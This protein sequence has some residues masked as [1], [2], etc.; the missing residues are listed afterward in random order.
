MNGG[1][2]I[3]DPINT[4]EMGNESSTARVE[5]LGHIDP[6]TLTEEEFNKHAWLYHA[7][8]VS[9]FSVCKHFDYTQA[10]VN[11]A[12]LG[13]GLYTTSSR[14]QA[15]NYMRARP[16]GATLNVLLPYHAKLLNLTDPNMLTNISVPN[17]IVEEW[18]IFARDKILASIK[19]KSTNWVVQQRLIDVMNKMNAINSEDHVDLRNDILDTGNSPFSIVDVLWR[20]F[21]ASKGW[22]GVIYVEGGIDD[23]SN[24]PDRTY[25]FYNIR[26]IGTYQDWQERSPRY[27][28]LDSGPS[29]A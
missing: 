3:G 25:I 6:T 29:Y 23:F 14:N 9:D 13:L 2:S 27:Y 10:A 21:C 12:T 28:P 20:E 4:E 8:R 24:T 22:D 16:E 26:T 17:D 19:D 11:D 15:E 18:I 1:E 5:V 7:S